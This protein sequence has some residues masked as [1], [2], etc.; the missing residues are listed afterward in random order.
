MRTSVGCTNCAHRCTK[1]LARLVARVRLAGDDELHGPLRVRQQPRQALGLAA[2]ACVGRL[3]SVKRRAKPSVSTFGSSVPSPRR[4]IS[5]LGAALAELAQQAPARVLD[6]VAALHAAELPQICA[7]LSAA[8][9][10]SAARSGSP[11]QRSLPQ[12]SV[13]RPI[14]PRRIPRRHVHGVG[15]V[16]HRHLVPRASAGRAGAKMPRLTAPCSSL[17][18]LMRAAGARREISHVER[19]VASSRI[20]PAQS[21]QLLRR[22]ADVLRVI[23]RRT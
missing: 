21:Q 15:H 17:T 3:Y 23:A 1:A 2:A 4:S 18:P 6:E 16:R 7:S 5:A 20:A 9:P 19:L 11:S 10:R 12:A 14:G 22:D 13:H 8:T